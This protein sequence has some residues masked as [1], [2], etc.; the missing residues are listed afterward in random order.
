[1]AEIRGQV[2]RVGQIWQT[3]FGVS[4]VVRIGDNNLDRGWQGKASSLEFEI[5]DDNSP[6]NPGIDP[7]HFCT[8][9]HLLDEMEENWSPANDYGGPFKLLVDADR[10]RFSVRRYGPR[11]RW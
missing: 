10:S 3:P 11:D 7:R 6:I 4:R 2:L 8:S 5:I 9:T 1:M